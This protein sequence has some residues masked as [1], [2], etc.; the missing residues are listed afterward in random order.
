MRDEP[1]G[2]VQGLRIENS[3][4]W[5]GLVAARTQG[6]QGQDIEIGDT[7]RQR[8]R[9]PTHCPCG[10]LTTESRKGCRQGGC[11][12]G[13]SAYRCPLLGF[14]LPAENRRSFK[15]LSGGMP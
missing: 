12:P 1:I 10:S 4:S 6:P 5:H 7:A 14:D 2:V 11:P 3:A 13:R 9:H 8:C 15:V